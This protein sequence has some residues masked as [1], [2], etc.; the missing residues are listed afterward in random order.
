MFGIKKGRYHAAKFWNA[1]YFGPA[2]G[3]VPPPTPSP[4]PVISTSG[5]RHRLVGSVFR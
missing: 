1:R 4:K 3:I 2:S 5:R